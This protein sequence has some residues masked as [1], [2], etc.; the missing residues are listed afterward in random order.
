MQGLLNQS[1][2]AADLLQEE[3]ASEVQETRRARQEAEVFEAEVQDVHGEVCEHRR[4]ASLA[5]EDLMHMTR[6]N[7]LLHNELLRAQ[8]RSR[9][10]LAA[11]REQRESMLPRL[12]ALRGSELQREQAA[13]AYQQVVD[14]RRRYEAAITEVADEVERS[15]SEVEVL[16]ARVLA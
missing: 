1:R 15:R 10:L 11:A 12:Q 6:E 7:Q 9:V 16:G 4:D 2:H 13:R 5:M 8:H 14:E 3:L